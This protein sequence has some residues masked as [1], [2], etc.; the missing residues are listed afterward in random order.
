[1]PTLLPGTGTRPVTASRPLMGMRWDTHLETYHT[2]GLSTS[3]ETPRDSQ[4]T[5]RGTNTTA[6]L[7][8]LSIRISPFTPMW[9]TRTPEA[10][11]CCVASL[12]FLRRIP[13]RSV[14]VGV[15]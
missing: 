2:R 9:D 11:K 6:R 15:A 14:R 5:R 7:R 1:V 4:H 12:F 13:P 3:A 8:M 10:S